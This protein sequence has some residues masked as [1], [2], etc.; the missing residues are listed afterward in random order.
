[1]I[2]LITSLFTEGVGYFKQK[3]EAKHKAQ[4]RDDKL[5]QAKLDAQ[6]K[7]L[8]SGDESAAKL[9]EL[10]IKQRGWKDE[11]LLILTTLPLGLSFIPDW[12]HIVDAGFAALDG[13]PEYYWYALGMI[14]V[15]TF[16]FRRMVRVAFEHW[17]QK[18]LGGVNG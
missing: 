13:V 12:T 17:L 16:G 1:M 10:S 2:G 9:D 4:E 15:D 3:Q 5:E 14:Y 7:R 18:R 8:Q 11:Y 6:I